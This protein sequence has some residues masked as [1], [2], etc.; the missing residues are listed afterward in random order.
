MN[1]QNVTFGPKY[2]QEMERRTKLQSHC[3]IR[4]SARAEPV[5]T[6][7]SSF[8][9]HGDLKTASYISGIMSFDFI[10]ILVAVEYILSGN[11]L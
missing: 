2:K 7:V 1:L 11:I 5:F 9:E 3:E 4:W 6:C 8:T 10:T